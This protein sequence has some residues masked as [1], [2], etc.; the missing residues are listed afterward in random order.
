MLDSS[1]CGGRGV[2][3]RRRNGGSTR[4]RTVSLASKENEEEEEKNLNSHRLRN[5]RLNKFSLTRSLIVM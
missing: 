5:K 1:I 3:T 4:N 2:V